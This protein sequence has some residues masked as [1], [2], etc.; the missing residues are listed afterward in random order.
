MLLSASGETS[1][2]YPIEDDPEPPDLNVPIRRVGIA[3]MARRSASGL[4]L[5]S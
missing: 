2:P 4:G 1:Q 3:G 5:D